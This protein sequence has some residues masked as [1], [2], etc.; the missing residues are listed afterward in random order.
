MGI[1]KITIFIS[2]GLVYILF[3]KANCNK[4]FDCA[5]VVYNFEIG[6]RANPDSDSVH[7]NDTIWFEINTP[8]KLNDLNRNQLIDYSGVENLGSAIGF[9]KLEGNSF[10]IKAA[11]KFKKIITTG[12]ETGN[13]D[14]E[15]FSE[16]L[17]INESGYY[18]FR[19]G[20]IPL[21]TGTYAIIFSNAANVYRK[22][23]KCTKAS[24][25]INFKETDQH[26]YLNPNFQGGPVPV[27]GDYYFKVIP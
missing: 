19:L 26:Y 2:L 9:E 6:V 10:T 24:F 25:T 21:D 15:L 3:V 12:K 5:R 8:D 20:V 13:A 27:G 7:I 16:Y 17:F 14:S 18:K 22:S 1:N 11:K 23:D 4:T